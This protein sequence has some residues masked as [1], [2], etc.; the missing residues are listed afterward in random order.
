MKRQASSKARKHKFSGA[1]SDTVLPLELRQAYG[2]PSSTLDHISS[3]SIQPIDILGAHVQPNPKIAIPRLRRNSE[4]AVLSKASVPGD[5][6]RVSHACEPCR[7]RKT[8]CSGERPVCQHCQDFDL[9]CCYAD[10]KRDKT[11]K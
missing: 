10:G 1:F 3:A 9:D 8:K 5:K 7:H 4:I 11:K 2:T 6:N